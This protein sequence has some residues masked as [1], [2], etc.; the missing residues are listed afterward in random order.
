MKICVISR[1]QSPEVQQTLHLHYTNVQ[2]LL[3]TKI[4][5]L[6]LF[7]IPLSEWVCMA[8]AFSHP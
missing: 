8:Q 5:Q 7:C 1:Q 3:I 2:R 6:W 4:T